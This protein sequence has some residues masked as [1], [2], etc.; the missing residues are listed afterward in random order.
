LEERLQE[1]QEQ[2]KTLKK[3]F[4]EVSRVEAQL[5]VWLTALV[6]AGKS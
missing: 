2:G 6:D 3:T 1:L 5:R 4:E